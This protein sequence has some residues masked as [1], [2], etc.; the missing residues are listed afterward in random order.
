MKEKK[1]CISY[2][3]SDLFAEVCAVSVISLFEN[4]KGL[5]S[6]TVFIIDDKISDKN[7]NR[8]FEMASKY[9][10]S[11]EFIPLPDPAT[12]YND[13]RFTIK[14]LGR[15]YARMILG[16]VLPKEYNYV[17]SLDSDTMILHSIEE[18]LKTDLTGFAMAGVDD[19]MGSVALVKTQH[20]PADTAHCNAGMY[21]IDLDTWKKED[22]TTLFFKYIKDLFD[23]DIAL[24]GY[25][26]EVMNKVLIGRI[27][28]LHPK[29]NLMTLEQVFSY[30]LIWKF[31]QPLSYYYKDDIDEALLNPVITHTTNFFYIKRRIFEDKSDHPMRS[32]YLKYRSITPWVDDPFMIIDRNFKQSVQK[33]FWHWMPIKIAVM[34]GA[35]VRNEI[36]PRLTKK[37]DDE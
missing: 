26:E 28:I 24:G 7:K 9:S 6:I 10:R 18:L 29:F 30:D 3:C 4:N 5:E 22:W 23:K 8:F 12:F 36:R 1:T 17:L 13:S 25:E 32:N 31:R 2:C 20:M 19:C 16:S 33:E 14:S 21:L 37:R 35:Y 11:V 15:T 27:K 34:I